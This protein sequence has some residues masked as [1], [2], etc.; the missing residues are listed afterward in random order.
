MPTYLKGT[1]ARDKACQL[2]LRGHGREIRVIM[3]IFAFIFL[4]LTHRHGIVNN[5]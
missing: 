2:I 5:L 4:I 1:R 3:S